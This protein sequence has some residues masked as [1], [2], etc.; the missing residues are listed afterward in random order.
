MVTNSKIV[1]LM[2]GKELNLQAVRYALVLDATE[3]VQEGLHDFVA[4]RIHRFGHV[5]GSWVQ[6]VEFVD[7]E[8]YALV[9]EETEILVMKQRAKVVCG[10]NGRDLNMLIMLS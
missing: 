1:I 10:E 6:Q 4:S 5:A 7:E 9:A 2:G 3:Q 8:N